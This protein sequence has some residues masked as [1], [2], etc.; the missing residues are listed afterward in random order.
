MLNM[1]HEI[2]GIL[3]SAAGQTAGLPAEFLVVD[4]GSSD[5]SMLEVLQL[6]KDMQLKGCVVQN[7]R[8]NLSSA[9]NTGLYKASGDYV[10]F[11]FP[12]RLYRDFF[13]GYY[14]TA[15]STEADF[16]FGAAA[17]PDEKAAQK[18][19]LK[20]FTGPELVAGLVHSAVSIDLG[21]VFLRRGF[22]SE[23]HI[24]FSEDCSFGYSEEFVYRVLLS[25]DNISQSPTPMTR[26]KVYEITGGEGQVVGNYCF[27]RVEAM[28]RIQNLIKAAHPEDRRLL[29]L[30]AGEKLPDTVLSCVELLLKEGNGYNAIRGAVRVKG[31]DS[32]LK[33]GKSTSASLRRR[34]LTWKTIPWMYQ[35]RTK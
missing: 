13:S 16:I 12:R 11:L 5:G 23:Q 10:T 25:T 28:L 2:T 17:A 14:E 33:A 32:L 9:L 6:I 15:L 20:K 8:G 24:R 27:D 7:G 26:D 4:M 34:L 19:K 21:A 18:M 22:L 30:F 3:R 29:D 31:Y 35:P 1:E